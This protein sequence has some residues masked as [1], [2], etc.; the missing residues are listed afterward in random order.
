[1]LVAATLTGTIATTV[2]SPF[3]AN[4]LGDVLAGGLVHHPHRQLHLAALV[5]AKHFH[6]HGVTD[7]DDVGGLG[8]PPWRELA[9]M[10]EPV[11]R[12]QEIHEGAKIGGLHHLAAIDHAHFRLGHDAADPVDRGLR[13]VAVIGGDLDG[14]VVLDIYLG[15]GLLH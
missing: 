13:L 15:A 10:H 14:A 6:L 8:N 9:D 5:E 11:A 7:V 1:A 3:G 4:L 2:A 12:T